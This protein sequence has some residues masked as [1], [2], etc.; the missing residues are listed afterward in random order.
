MSSI[1]SRKITPARDQSYHLPRQLSH[2]PP[3][4]VLITRLNCRES[5]SEREPVGVWPPEPVPAAPTTT[6]VIHT[7]S[8]VEPEDASVVPM[9]RA[10]GRTRS[11]PELLSLRFRSSETTEPVAHPATRNMN[12]LSGQ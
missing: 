9:P 11:A 5:H 6:S 12:A 10:Q 2:S 1:A 3:S 7:R 8:S 4:A